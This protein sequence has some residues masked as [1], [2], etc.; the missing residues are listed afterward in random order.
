MSTNLQSTMRMTHLAPVAAALVLAASV[1]TARAEDRP[2]PVMDRPVPIILDTDIQTD[3]DDVGAVAMAHALADRGEAE[4]LAIG[5]SVTNPWSVLCLSAI[6]TYFGR[7]DLPIG[8]IRGEGYRAPSRY[9]EQVAEEFPRSLES[10]DA[11]P[12]AAELY[13]RV[14]AARPDASV[15]M[16]SVGQVTNF[17]N[18]LQTKPDEHSPL[19]GRA[20]V[21]RKVRLW[22]CMGG[23][24]PDGREYNLHTDRGAAAYA[25][26]HW[27]TPIVFSGYEIGVRIQTGRGLREAAKTSPVRRAY[28]L[29]NQISNRC[30]WDQAAVLYAV[31]GASGQIDEHWDLAGPGRVTVDPANG[32]NTWQVDAKGR[33]WYKVERRSP[34]LIAEEIERLM[35]H[36][37]AQPVAIGSPLPGQT[38]A[39][40]EAS[41]VT[42]EVQLGSRD[43]PVREVTLHAGDRQLGSRGQEPWTFTWVQPTAGWHRLTARV[44]FD[45]GQEA[46]SQ[47]VPVYMLAT[48]TPAALPAVTEGLVA[49]YPLNEGG[50]RMVRDRSGSGLAP[51]LWI[52]PETSWLEGGAGL[53][54]DHDRA[55][56]SSERPA[57]RLIERLRDTGALTVEFWM[58]PDELAQGGP[59]RL[60]TLSQNISRRNLTLGHGQHRDAGPNLSVRL[61]TTHTDENGMPDLVAQNAIVAARAQYVVTYAGHTMAVYRDGRLIHTASRAGAMS[62]W[63]HDHLLALGNEPGADR[64]WRGRLHRVAIYDRAL[65]AAEVWENFDAG[66]PREESLKKPGGPDFE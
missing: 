9:A 11:A 46:E 55:G 41:E 12:D 45:D 20:L 64:A 51:D 35:M 62:N 65:N 8:M 36:E 28:E 57:R 29:Y 58:E 30:S 24:F 56:A 25:I 5:V 40:D 60:V 27:P 13:R 23:R 44:R 52:T 53:R 61:R 10:A 59:A 47:P 66:L 63:S 18:L 38:I 21:E 2:V 33:H 19:D 4:L 6:N 17:R 50:G 43:R 49:S 7:G 3:I 34:E 48:E 32:A 22:V 16:V 37:P 14:L 42:V 31:R 39:A 1:A 26:A 54:F 15:V